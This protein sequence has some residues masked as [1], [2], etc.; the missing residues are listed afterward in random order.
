MLVSPSIC[1]PARRKPYWVLNT[2][3]SVMVTSTDF[4][5]ALSKR[6]LVVTLGNF[7]ICDQ[8]TPLALTLPALKILLVAAVSKSVSCIDAGTWPD[9]TAGHWMLPRVEQAAEAAVAAREPA[10]QI[11]ARIV[12][13]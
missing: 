6:E 5:L 2:E 4:M 12:Y 7:K 3:L 1:K 10:R 9:S 11:D 13:I 8:G